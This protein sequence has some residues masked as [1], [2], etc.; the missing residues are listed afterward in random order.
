MFK[1]GLLNIYS[2]QLSLIHRFSDS[3][4]ISLLFLYFVN[5]SPLD[6]EYYFELFLFVFTFTSLT[7]SIGNIYRSFRGIK[8]KNIV[9]NIVT[10]WFFFLSSSSLLLFITKTGY[11]F[12]R[13]EIIYWQLS[14]LIVLMI[15]HLL[16]RKLLRIIRINDRNTR[17]ILFCGSE[18]SL[19]KIKD[20]IQ[21]NPWTGF[22]IIAFFC[23]E[24]CKKNDFINKNEI[25]LLKNVN[26]LQI[27]LEK[28]NVDLAII[29]SEYCD[30]QDKLINVI[31]NTT[32]PLY[33]M[34]FIPIQNTV[35]TLGNIGNQLFIQIYGKNSYVFDQAI[36]VSFDY[37]FSFLLFLILSPL[38]ILIAIGIKLS[39]K[40]PIIY[41]QKRYGLNG[42]SFNIYKFRTMHIFK[43][44]SL[45]KKQATK[46]DK[47]I[48]K[49]GL[50]LRKY[51]LDE[52]PQL[53]NVLK[54]NMSLVGPRPHADYHNEYY[55]KIIKGYM[56]RHSLKPGMTGLSQVND[57]RGETKKIDE[58]KRRVETDLKYIRD[59][60][61]LLD[62]L[63]LIKTSL[64][65]SSK[66]AF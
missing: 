23:N 52:L 25:I 54:G 17:N 42:N 10:V 47:R 60:S 62:F 2:N 15:T 56:Q 55:R 38:F 40:G 63:I 5:T 4:F 1:H 57:L 18:K 41:K 3:F 64:K 46:N 33:L 8:L 28:N 43:V 9:V 59:W 12:S 27:W 29:S 66:K 51:S 13:L 7:L 35:F 11:L 21:S 34:P 16:S 61:L 20:E 31:G 39:S 22:K 50:F 36:K 26:Q 65:L 6:K 49:F 37:I 19:F 45:M 48:F 14:V 24:E 32:I 30:S 44:G 53:F 58:M